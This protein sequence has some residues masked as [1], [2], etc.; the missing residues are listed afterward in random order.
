MAEEWEKEVE[1]IIDAQ[2]NTLVHL[3]EARVSKKE[4][5]VPEK[6]H[7]ENKK[8]SDHEEDPSSERP[9]MPKELMVAKDKIRYLAKFKERTFGN[10]SS[11]ICSLPEERAD[12]Q[13]IID[14]WEQ[15]QARGPE[16]AGSTH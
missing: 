6:K 1:L 8:K 11:I 14:D 9:P 7:G 2:I 5:R 3:K 12:L 16:C 10:S 15:T 4:A 13:K